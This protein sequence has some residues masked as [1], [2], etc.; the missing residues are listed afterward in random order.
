MLILRHIHEQT[1]HG[2][3]NYSLSKLRERYW[4]THAN[5]AARKLLSSCVFCKRHRAKLCEQKMADLPKER[6]T[7]DLPPFTNVGV[8][9]F[10]PFEV[11]QGRSNVKRYGVVFTC[12]ASRAVHLEVAHSLDTDSCISAIRRFIC[13]RGRVSHFRSDNG[14]NFK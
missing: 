4:I 6:T 3:R 1:G 11:K 10:G 8:D 5:A 7:P 14:T 9:Y 13:R 2:G 12:M